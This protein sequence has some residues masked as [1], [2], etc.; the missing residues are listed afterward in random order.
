M[1]M[2]T[3]PYKKKYRIHIWNSELLLLSIKRLKM[4]GEF[5]VPFNVNQIQM[6]NFISTEPISTSL[7][8]PKE[9]VLLL[10]Y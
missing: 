8:D 1:N 6:H 10:M 3:Y 9:S 7:T 5:L 2:Q 4:T